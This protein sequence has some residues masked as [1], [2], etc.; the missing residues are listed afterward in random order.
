MQASANLIR[1]YELIGN[2]MRL[3]MTYTGGQFDQGLVG[4]AVSPDYKYLLA[5]SE[6]KPLLWD[7]FTG[8]QVSLDHLNVILK[9]RLTTC[10][11][12]PKYNLVALSGFI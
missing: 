3:H 6:G 10:D 8:G 12:H 1:H 2:P 9:K 4:C 7:V 11:W 5:P